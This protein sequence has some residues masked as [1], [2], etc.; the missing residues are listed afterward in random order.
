MEIDEVINR[1]PGVKAGMAVGFE[2]DFYGEEV[3][4]YCVRE[5]GSNLMAEEFLAACSAKLPWERR[6]KVVVFGEEF[7]VTSTGK[8][9]RNKLK[10]LFAQYRGTSFSK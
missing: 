9:Q 8:Y 1:V 3:G 7:P 6:P 10:P 5:P 2:N 4:A